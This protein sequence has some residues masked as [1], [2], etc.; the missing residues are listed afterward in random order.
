MKY[1]PELVEMTE[2]VNVLLKSIESTGS[3]ELG[4]DGKIV[5]RKYVVF[6]HNTKG[7]TSKIGGNRNE[8]EGFLMGVIAGLTMAGA[9]M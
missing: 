4:D 3:I 7:F 9:R 6:I 5:R 1:D 8:M 2:K